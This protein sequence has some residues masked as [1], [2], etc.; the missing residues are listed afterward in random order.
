MRERLVLDLRPLGIPAVPQLGRYSYREAHRGL[1][2]HV[3]RDAL[4]IC[5]LAR[6]R[7]LYRVGRRDFVLTGGDVFVTFPGEVHS[8]G[9]APEEKGTLYWVQLTDRKSVV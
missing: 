3:H 5:Y 8:T 6:G 4:E 2:L 9:E 7:Q 1:D